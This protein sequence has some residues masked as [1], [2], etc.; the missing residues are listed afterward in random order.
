MW[1]SV[2][3]KLLAPVL[4][5]SY[6]PLAFSPWVNPKTLFAANEGEFKD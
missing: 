1:Q 6:W 5:A 2:M 4:A 3:N